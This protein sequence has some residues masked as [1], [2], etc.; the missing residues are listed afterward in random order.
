M[1]LLCG[2]AFDSYSK[3]NF[4]NPLYFVSKV[5]MLSMGWFLLVRHGNQNF[6]L[7]TKGFGW[8]M[9]L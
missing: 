4:R 1:A 6:I 7:I 2:D 3:L 8:I 5:N 9:A